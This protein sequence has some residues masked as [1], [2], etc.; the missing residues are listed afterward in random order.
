M[1]HAEKLC[2]IES[3]VTTLELGAFLRNQEAV[4][5]EKVGCVFV[6]RSHRG[7]ANSAITASGCRDGKDRICCWDENAGDYDFHGVSL[8][9][10]EID[11]GRVETFRRS[12][13]LSGAVFSDEGHPCWSKRSESS[14]I[15]FGVDFIRRL[16]HH[17]AVWECPCVSPLFHE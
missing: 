15:A 16:Q 2:L 1:I 13:V 5:P 17:G 8:F 11:Y 10:G 14:S 7:L 6:V 4:F 12:H 9:I 3:M